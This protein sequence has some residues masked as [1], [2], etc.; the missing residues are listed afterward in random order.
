M[1]SG[2]Q[3][4]SKGEVPSGHD[5]AGHI[6]SCFARRGSNMAAQQKLG[7]RAERHSRPGRVGAARSSSNGPDIARAAAAR[8]AAGNCADKRTAVRVGGLEPKT[9]AERID[10]LARQRHSWR[11]TLHPPEK[12][13]LPA[14][15]A[16]P[17]AVMPIH[18]LRTV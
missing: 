17:P 7:L 10:T 16:R 9:K 2:G 3:T 5:S 4:H 1:R 18:H 14:S 8:S 11:L 15:R 13:I 12:R 6:D